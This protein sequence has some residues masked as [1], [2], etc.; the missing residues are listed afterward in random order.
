M[1]LV[2]GWSWL[3]V[4]KSGG[5]GGAPA[6]T[7]KPR[8]PQ[9]GSQPGSAKRAP[10]HPTSHPLTPPPLP[11]APSL[12]QLAA[13]VYVILFGVGERDT[14]GIYSLRAFGDDGLPIETIIIFEQVRACAYRWG[15]LCVGM[16]TGWVG[17]CARARAYKWGVVGERQRGGL[18]GGPTRAC[19]HASRV[20]GRRRVPLSLGAPLPTTTCPA[21]LHRTAGGGRGAVRG[22]AGGDDGP[23]AQ[24]V[25][26]RAAGAH[27][28][29]RRAGIQVNRI[30]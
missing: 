4:V 30:E 29:L 2:G 17:G 15:G 18:R 21:P 22:P 25:L 28:L 1:V 14:E 23:Q 7:S 20:G 27:G 24:R 11:P 13:Q 3:E 10:P 12:P 16:R 19:V 9:P 6:A 5:A 8:S 26:H